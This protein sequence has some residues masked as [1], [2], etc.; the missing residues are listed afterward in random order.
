MPTARA[1]IEARL[2]P[3]EA[4]TRPS[5]IDAVENIC[6]DLERQDKIDNGFK[7]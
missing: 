5:A 1:N 4:Y 2:L 3:R 6:V 7:R